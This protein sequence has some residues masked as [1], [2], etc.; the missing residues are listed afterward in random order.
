MTRAVLALS[1]ALAGSPVAALSPT[2]EVALDCLGSP[3]PVWLVICADA[4]LTA[5]AIAERAMA[6]GRAPLDDMA[7]LSDRDRC[8]LGPAPTACLTDLYI[9][10]IERLGRSG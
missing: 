8:A 2:E 5:L 6:R 3:R 7:F 4:T 10:R 9:R 1:M